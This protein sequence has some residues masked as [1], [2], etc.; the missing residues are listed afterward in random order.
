M[1]SAQTRHDACRARR[2]SRRRPGH[3]PRR[4]WGR[5]RGRA[6]RLPAGPAGCQGSSRDA[7]ARSV[8]AASAHSRS[9][10]RCARQE[11]AS[12]GA[13]RAW[14]GAPEGLRGDGALREAHAGDAEAHLR[15]GVARARDARVSRRNK[16]QRASASLRPR[17]RRSSAAAQRG[18]RLRARLL[19]VVHE[20]LVAVVLPLPQPLPLVAAGGART[21]VLSHRR[22]R[23]VQPPAAAASQPASVRVACVRSACRR[24][25]VER[26]RRSGA[27]RSAHGRGAH[28]SDGSC[29]QCSG[30]NTS[31]KKPS[32]ICGH[33]AC[34]G[35][36]R[37]VSRARAAT[38]HA[39]RLRRLRR[40]PAA[41]CG[42]RS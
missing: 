13:L 7:G 17:L 40:A 27:Q 21:E 11:G 25:T 19:V 6:C 12:C 1:R 3:A 31:S 29:R 39:P 35:R 14:R 42:P 36:A 18:A 16:L 24:C 33:E 5:M 8:A 4:P 26:S 30:T 2:V 37:A 41:Q 38:Q 23:G 9:R 10:G 20:H 34:R 28:N 22:A 15:A 32:V